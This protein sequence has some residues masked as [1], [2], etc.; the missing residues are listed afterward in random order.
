MKF[1]TPE[2]AVSNGWL[3]P[4]GDTTSSLSWGNRK[5]G[6]TAYDYSTP[7]AGLKIRIVKYPGT[8]GTAGA[9][10]E[11]AISIGDIVDYAGGL[12][13]SNSKGGGYVSFSAPG[14]TMPVAPG[15]QMTMT[16][17]QFIDYMIV[18]GAIDSTQYAQALTQYQIRAGIITGSQRAGMQ[19]QANAPVYGDDYGAWV[20]EQERISAGSTRAGAMAQANAPV[21]TTAP[22]ETT[23]EKKLDLKPIIGIGL[24]LKAL[25]LLV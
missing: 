13:K 11:S 5:A 10:F 19:A 2:Q 25:S 3:I 1:T 12:F 4:L 14:H 6:V 16:P 8:A 7:N 24:G 18:G 17:E 20:R 21:Y 9:V 23:T 15:S 22:V